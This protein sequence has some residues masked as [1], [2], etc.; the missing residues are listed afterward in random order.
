M[1]SRWRSRY[2][3][4]QCVMCPATFTL[5]PHSRAVTC[6]PSCAA[7]LGNL[8]RGPTNC[9]HCAWVESWRLTR[10]AEIRWI[11]VV[12]A[13]QD[14]RPV[15]LKEFMHGWGR[16]EPTPKAYRHYEWQIE[17]GDT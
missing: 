6:S 15:T 4:V 13:D 14:R 7:R 10:D 2:P 12:G 5:V 1:S 3:R 8:D 11:Q 9:W 17:E 16:T